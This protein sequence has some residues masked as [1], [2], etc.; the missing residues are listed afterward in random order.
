MPAAAA[1]MQP[2]PPDDSHAD[3][4]VGLAKSTQR[5]V[6][7]YHL[8]RP[9]GS[10]AV[11]SLT[12]NKDSIY[13]E[14]LSDESSPHQQ[15]HVDGA[16]ESSRRC[17]RRMVRDARTG[18]DGR[19]RV[20]QAGPLPRHTAILRLHQGLS[21]H[22]RRPSLRH[23]CQDVRDADNPHRDLEADSLG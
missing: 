1:P 20:G 11:G 22:D 13:F 3:W 15:G 21:L 9:S 17:P 6:V 5:K 8:G 12:L 19:S 7:L 23:D 10:H 16:D 2:N 18:A 4:Q 14:L